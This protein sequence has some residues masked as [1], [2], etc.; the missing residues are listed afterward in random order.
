MLFHLSM[1]FF[2]CLVDSGH[3]TLMEHKAAKWLTKNKLD[4]VAWLPADVNVVE[5]YKGRYM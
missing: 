1:Q 2:L 3:I 4:T 5:V